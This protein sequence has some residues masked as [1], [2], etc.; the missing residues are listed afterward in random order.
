MG[1]EK[2]KKYDE[3]VIAS[4]GAFGGG[5]ASSGSVCGALLGA[6]ATISALYSRGNLNQKENPR[7]WGVSHKVISKFNALTEPFGGQNCSDIARINWSDREATKRYYSA[8]ESSRK[9][10]I[11]LVGDL[12]HA[13][14]VILDKEMV[15]SGYSNKQPPS[16]SSS[17]SSRPTIRGRFSSPNSIKGQKQHSQSQ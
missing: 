1:L 13:L 5:I 4:S 8:P 15:K 6:V 16:S 9:D 11:K 17:N 3:N 12:A 7:I 14:G 10:C 2:I